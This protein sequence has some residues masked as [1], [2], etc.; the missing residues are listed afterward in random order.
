MHELKQSFTRG[1]VRLERIQVIWLTLGVVV[2][3]GMMFTLGLI[4][5][6]RAAHLAP[7]TAADPLAE[8]E[9]NGKMHEQ[10]TFYKGLTQ[11]PTPQKSK[12]IAMV[13]APA[14]VPAP[15]VKPATAPVKPAPTVN[16][17]SA[18]NPA[19]AVVKP[20][21]EQDEPEATPPTQAPSKKSPAHAAVAAET[22][23]AE[24]TALSKDPP[25]PSV[26]AALDQGP[27]SHGEFTVQVSSFTTEREANAAAASLR[28][29]GFTPFIVSSDVAKRGTWY[30]VRLGR[31][32]KQ[33]DAAK[34]K[35]ILASADIPAWVL[36]V[37]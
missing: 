36:K 10:L 4:V 33:A 14:P 24:D 8:I 20:E 12:P 17:A 16:P 9:A 29:K 32:T 11:P 34:A 22:A 7:Q 28:R 3:L 23:D 13:Q 15:A 6:R 1:D 27:A 2:A 35:G 25:D 31:F 18:T 5:G 26:R 30:R 19:P 21:V 37:Q